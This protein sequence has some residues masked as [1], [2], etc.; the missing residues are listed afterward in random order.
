MISPQT[1]MRNQSEKPFR[2]LDLPPEMRNLIYSFVFGEA[3]EKLAFPIIRQLAPYRAYMTPCWCSRQLD[4]LLTCKKVY[5]EAFEYVHGIV[6]GSIHFSKLP[7]WGEYICYYCGDYHKE[8]TVEQITRTLGRY[9]HLME[10]ITHL[11]V[12]GENGESL[13]WEMFGGGDQRLV[14]G[15]GCELDLTHMRQIVRDLKGPLR[16]VHAI[17]VF[18]GAK[19]KTAFRKRAASLAYHRF[20]LGVYPKL[21]MICMM[22]DNGTEVIMRRDPALIEA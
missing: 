18:V 1:V 14:K 16:N 9:G 6:H 21:R 22:T 17:T 11:D 15:D 10:N 2:F 13:I 20:L 12:R 5:K 8:T 3:E 19:D 7:G 4:L